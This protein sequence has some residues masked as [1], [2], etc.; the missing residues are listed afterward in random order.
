[1]H[2]RFAPLGRDVVMDV[3]Q[4]TNPGRSGRTR[5]GPKKRM[6]RVDGLTGTIQ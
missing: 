5:C 1:M 2:A 6:H 4:G 3:A